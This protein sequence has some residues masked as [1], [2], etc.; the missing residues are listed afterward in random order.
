MREET[1]INKF[2]ADNGYKLIYTDKD[3]YSMWKVHD[4]S[5]L[6]IVHSSFSGD[7]QNTVFVEIESLK[8]IIAK[9]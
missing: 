5:L 6:E 7:D 9:L 3:M 4:D 2:L 8:E 1:K